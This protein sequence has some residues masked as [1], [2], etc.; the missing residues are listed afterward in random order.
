MG[1]L[2]K[3]IREA[4]NGSQWYLDS[5]YAENGELEAC[6]LYD[7]DGYFVAEFYAE[8]EAER[9]VDGIIFR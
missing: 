7:P 4:A 3:S 9:F 5:F 2:V 6:R 8:G 1:K